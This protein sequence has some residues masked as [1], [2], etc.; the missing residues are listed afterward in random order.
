M[1]RMRVLTAVLLLAVA[2]SGC[3]LERFL[4]RSPTV[5]I[6]WVD[7]VKVRGITY[8]MVHGAGRTL[9]PEDLGEPFDSVRFRVAGNVTDSS[10]RTKNG[11]AAFL[12]PGTVLYAVKG[13]NTS[14]RLAAAHDG[15]LF[16][17]EADSNPGAKSGADLLDLKGK[18]TRLTIGNPVDGGPLTAIVDPAVVAR[19]VDDVLAAPVFPEGQRGGDATAGEKRYMLTFHFAD[20]TA[21]VRSYWPDTGFLWA[22]PGLKVPDTFRDAVLAAVK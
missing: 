19:L 14:F 2:V 12:A 6:D 22:G 4:G 10:Y 8:L 5:M 20:G 21:T 17:F 11:D 15:N 7:F 3:G 16:L 9:V 1:R 18:V 13:Y